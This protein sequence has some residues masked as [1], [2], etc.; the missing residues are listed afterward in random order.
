MMFSEN[1]FEITKGPLFEKKTPLGGGW[2]TYFA[3]KSNGFIFPS[4]R[5]EKFDKYLK[6]PPPNVEKV[7]TPPLQKKR[8]KICVFQTDLRRV[9][10]PPQW[11]W[12]EILE[13]KWDPYFMSFE[14]MNQFPYNTR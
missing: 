8:V 12:F 9:Q 6:K 3:K 7:L 4:F 14:L 2:T 11:H 10:N 1:I 13:L 5:G